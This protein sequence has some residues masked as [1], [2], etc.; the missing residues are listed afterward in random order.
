MRTTIVDKFKHT[1]NDKQPYNWQIDTCEA[2][3]LR[4]DCIVIAG[5]GA[6]KTLLFAMPLLMDSTCRKMVIV[7]SPLRVLEYDQVCIQSKQGGTLAE[8]ELAILSLIAQMESHIKPCPEIIDVDMEP[9]TSKKH[10]EIRRGD[11]L[12]KCCDGLVHWH[13]KCWHDNYAG[14]TWGVTS[15]ISD[16]VINELATWV[17]ITTV[18]AI[19]LEISEWEFAERH[20]ADILVV[21]ELADQQWKKEKENCQV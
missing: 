7:I 12:Q 1:F 5:T 6:S 18:D 20:G 17:H 13:V 10:Q 19:K 3:L 4:L 8:E 2:L 15:L 14:S 21:V 16:A 9:M 11:R